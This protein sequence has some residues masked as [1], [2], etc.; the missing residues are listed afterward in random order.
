M[1]VLIPSGRP[2][3]T[4]GGR[5]FTDLANLIQYR[6]ELEGSSTQAATMIRLTASGPAGLTA[7]TTAKTYLVYAG[8]AVQGVTGATGNKP[9]KLAYGDTSVGVGGASPPA[10]VVG[11]LSGIASGND[12]DG[13][14]SGIVAGANPG[15]VEEA[16]NCGK[17]VATKFPCVIATSALGGPFYISVWGYES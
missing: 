17:V 1:A 4:V 11:M 12:A 14:M 9:F 3:I 8:R 5:V 10:N 15:Y 13:F 7:V 2:T 6:T 16:F